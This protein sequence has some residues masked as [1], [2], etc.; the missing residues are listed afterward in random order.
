[1]K[2]EPGG[3]YQ[4]T[5]GDEPPN[6]EGNPCLT[7]PRIFGFRFRRP[8]TDIQPNSP[9]T[10]NWVDDDAAVAIATQAG[11]KVGTGF[12][13]GFT[14]PEWVY[15]DGDLVY[16]YEML[17]EDPPG[18]S[19]GSQPLPFDTVYQDKL[20]T[21]IQ[22]QGA[23]YDGNP[24]ISYIMIAGFMQAL[25]MNYAQ[26]QEDMDAL[27]ALAVTPPPGY[28]GLTVS[29]PNFLT[30][31][32]DAAKKIIDMYAL[33]FPQTPIILT[34]S[35]PFPTQAGQ[36]AQQEIKQYGL[37]TYPGHF[38]TMVSALYAVLPP[39]APGPVPTIQYPKLFQHAVPSQNISRIYNPPIPDPIPDAPQ[40]FSD[41][42][43]H[44]VTLGGKLEE[45]YIGDA[46][47][48]MNQAVLDL[49]LPLLL[50]NLANAEDQQPPP[51]PGEETPTISGIRSLRFREV[52]WGVAHKLGWITS[53][54]PL[55]GGPSDDQFCELVTFCNAWLRKLWDAEDW[56][57]WTKIL[58]VRP[59]A[60]H[61]VLI[62][63]RVLRM[64]LNDPDLVPG[65]ID[66]P[67]SVLDG[68]VHCG[69]E[70][71][72]NVWLKYLPNPPVFTEDKWSSIVTYKI[73]DLVYSPISGECYKSLINGNRDHDPAP[74]ILSGG[75]RFDLSFVVTQE[76][77]PGVPTEP[78]T[79]EVWRVL[80]GNPPVYNLEDVLYRFQFI[81]TDGGQHQVAY[82]TPAPG[83]TLTDLTNGITAAF[84]A[85]LDPFILS[86]TV[87]VVGTL[88]ATQM[89]FELA[90][91]HFSARGT[92][93]IGPGPPVDLVLEHVSVYNPG[94]TGQDEVPQLA[95]LTL[96]QELD[97][98]SALYTIRAQ[99]REGNHQVSYTS[100]PDEALQVTLEGIIQAIND[101][102]AADPFWGTVI[103]DPDP[104][105]D[106]IEFLT[107]E[108]V[109]F[110]ATAESQFVP[111]TVIAWEQVIFPMVIA[112][113]VMRG[114]YSDALREEGQTDKAGVEETATTQELALATGK[115]INQPYDR[116]TDQQQPRSRYRM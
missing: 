64:F 40:P 60:R 70:H 32:V 37:D 91:A 97:L 24:N 43:L 46:T 100:Q 85:S 96:E 90:T 42:C 53:C 107:V 111:D 44:G 102:A 56:N 29:W 106:T 116:M 114:I 6:L 4:L 101:A 3:F 34:I 8:W 12:A 66:A 112:E 98:Q 25:G 21:F 45:I 13:A 71:G 7:N 30:G 99:N 77:V 65:P 72:S 115:S 78:P 19:I 22:A 15:T 108:T 82:V 73:G 92:V 5:P 28:D 87:S 61:S 55:A 109:R 58:Q 33:A 88:E 1:M 39:H 51:I 52:I 49:V 48:E 27:D 38:G 63:G 89:Q 50:A 17:E 59:D 9:T 31:Y 74:I 23:K 26:T 20:N 103:A 110:Q 41:C 95:V 35:N 86:L 62:P 68:R 84:A 14:T 105:T 57:E 2:P 79:S 18:T 36:A 80:V 69:F 75:G 81:D 94:H 54:D 47:A 16:K 83:G 67:F 93:D 76:F 10:Y 11:K 104:D 113:P